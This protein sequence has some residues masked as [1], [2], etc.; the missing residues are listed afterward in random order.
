MRERRNGRHHATGWGSKFKT[1]TRSKGMQK[2][3]CM[4]MAGWHQIARRAPPGAARRARAGGVDLVTQGHQDLEAIS[5][6]TQLPILLDL[7][8]LIEFLR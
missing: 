5:P 1:C 2:A 8:S 3:I 7:L 6:V 4:I